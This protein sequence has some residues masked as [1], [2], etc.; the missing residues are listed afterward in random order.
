MNDPVDL[1]IVG[2]GPA[3]IEAAIVAARAG[4]E[5]VLIDLARQPGGQYF[6]QLPVE[7]QYEDASKLHQKS[8]K[9]LRALENA[10]VRIM[11][12]TLVWGIFQDVRA[13][14][15]SLALYG[16]HRPTLLNTRALILAT[17]AYER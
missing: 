5:V 16:Q 2:A 9:R 4:L 1:A 17:G 13:G 12:E 14:E 3:G 15:W 8:E 7:F 6:K 10:N 11:T